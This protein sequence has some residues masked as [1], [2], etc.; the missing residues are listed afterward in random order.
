MRFWNDT[1]IETAI[2]EKSKLYVKLANYAP[3]EKLGRDDIGQLMFILRQ[4]EIELNAIR[5]DRKRK[6]K[7]ARKQPV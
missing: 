6:L 4:Y 7:R 3:D 5:S 1:A 2:S